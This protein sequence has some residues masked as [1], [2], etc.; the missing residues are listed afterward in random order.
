MQLC[1]TTKQSH[2]KAV[3]TQPTYPLFNRTFILW[4]FF[5]KQKK[6]QPDWPINWFYFCSDPILHG[7]MLT[8]L[9]FTRYQNYC[10]KYL[11]NMQDWATLK[12][13]I[14]FCFPLFF[15]L[16]LEVTIPNKR[17]FHFICHPFWT[18]SRQNS[19]CEENLLEK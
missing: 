11:E 17:T 4:V 15:H 14:M 5:P 13:Q 19:V 8:S 16:H 9:L 18:M 6:Q 2:T 10:C 3:H 7:G 12:G 1:N